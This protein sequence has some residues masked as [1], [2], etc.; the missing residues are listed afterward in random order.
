MLSL[1]SIISKYRVY[2]VCKIYIDHPPTF[3]GF[4]MSTFLFDNKK[5]AISGGVYLNRMYTK[6]AYYQKLY[7][8][9]IYDWL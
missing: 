7:K 5:H 4:F 9:P 2:K 1:M 3:R 6:G 8:Q